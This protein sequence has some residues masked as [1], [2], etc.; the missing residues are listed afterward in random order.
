MKREARTPTFGWSVLLTLVLVLFLPTPSDSQESDELDEAH[1]LFMQGEYEKAAKAFKKIR[2]REKTPSFDAAMGLSASY[3]RIGEFRKAAD[4]ADEALE[5]AST[6]AEEVAAYGQIGIAAFAQGTADQQ[7]FLAAEEALRQ[8]VE[9]DPDSMEGVRY[10]YGVVLLRLERDEEGVAF[11]QDFLERYPDGPTAAQARSYVEDPRRARV[12]VI[13]DFTATTL[14]GDEVSP[15]SL[16]GKVVLFDFWGTW[17][18]PCRA[19]IP[20]LRKLSRKSEKEPFLIVGVAS[21][22]SET[23]VRDFTA[24]NEMGWPQI[25]DSN[26]ILSMRTFGI[27]SYPTYVLVDHEG[28]IVFQDSGYS[29]RMEAQVSNAVRKALRALKRSN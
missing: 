11:I 5:L 13:P 3:S 21:E 24:E 8:V 14:D 7:G 2:K 15:D 23:T 6:P 20:H 18:A 26:R 12:P 22:R 25:L 1:A 9:R 4:V 16:L 17:C 28:V 10:L 19:S 27:Q 29:N